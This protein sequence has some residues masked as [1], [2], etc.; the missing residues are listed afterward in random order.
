ML[1]KCRLIIIDKEHKLNLNT[2][3]LLSLLLSAIIMLQQVVVKK[4][5]LPQ[6]KFM[7][8]SETLRVEDFTGNKRLFPAKSGGAPA[9]VKVPGRTHPVSIHHSKQTELDDYGKFLSFIG[10]NSVSGF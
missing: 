10:A 4:G 9:L 8:R 6:L 3:A 2:Y 7:I 5:L 1:Q